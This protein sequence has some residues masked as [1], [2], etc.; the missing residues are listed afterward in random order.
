M[1]L[2]LQTYAPLDDSPNHR[3]IYQFCCVNAQCLGKLRSWIC[4]RDEISDSIQ[5]SVAPYVVPKNLQPVVWND[6]A[7]DWGDGEEKIADQMKGNSSISDCNLDI[8]SLNLEDPI[9]TPCNEEE[10]FPSAELEIESGEESI[11]VDLPVKPSI[12][13]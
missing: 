5:E 11:S 9:S 7:D 12:D 6:D 8:K 3:T 10:M 1:L 4:L 2:V 13:I